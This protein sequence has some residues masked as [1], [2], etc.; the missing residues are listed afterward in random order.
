MLKKQVKVFV[1]FLFTVFM[2]CSKTT[3]VFAATN[4]VTV[5]SQ[6]SYE[7]NDRYR[8]DID[9]IQFCYKTTEEVVTVSGYMAGQPKYGTVLKKGE[10]M[11]YAFSK[12]S[13]V[14]VSLG[15]SVTFFGVASPSIS[16]TL[17]TTQYTDDVGGVIRKASQKG[18]YKLYGKITY[19]IT[20][21]VTYGRPY[22]RTYN[23][24]KGKYVYKYGDW[25]YY[26]C[27]SK[28]YELLKDQSYLDK[29][30]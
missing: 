10:G 24:S 3:I 30:D 17:P 12:S 29:I 11:Y 2:I 13:G 1:L 18:T 28:T 19:K 16:I 26:L 7:D 20:T 4:N 15:A 8:D 23:K 22:T 21:K 25:Q 5:I 9:M 6:D 27:R 14:S